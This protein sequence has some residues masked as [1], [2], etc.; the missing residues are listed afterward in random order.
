MLST[1]YELSPCLTSVNCKLISS[2]AFCFLNDSAVPLHFLKLLVE[3][4]S[5]IYYYFNGGV[6]GVIIIIKIGFPYS[7]ATEKILLLCATVI[8]LL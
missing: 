8:L 5:C 6:I 3:S 4:P 1:I 2:C 7:C